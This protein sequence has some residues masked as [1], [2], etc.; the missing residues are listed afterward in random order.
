MKKLVRF[1]VATFACATSFAGPVQAQALIGGHPPGVSGRYAQPVP[2]GDSRP[3]IGFSPEGSA[4]P[5]V[6][7][8]IDSAHRSLHVMAYEMKDAGIVRALSE[9]AARGVD[10]VVQVDYREN[11]GDG[12]SDFTRK[13]LSSLAA[14]GARVC[15]ISA[16]PIFHSNRKPGGC[17]MA[18][19][20]PVPEF[21]SVDGAVARRHPKGRH[22]HEDV[23][24]AVRGV[25]VHDFTTV[26]VLLVKCVDIDAFHIR[27]GNKT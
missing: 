5:L 9:K 6:M 18:L 1:V 21:A 2:A 22:E 15:V 20:G 7:R 11:I 10:V 13:R 16:F 25:E 23:C 27:H 8:V 12:S 24:H 14:S 26:T 3:E 4:Y 19:R 17:Y